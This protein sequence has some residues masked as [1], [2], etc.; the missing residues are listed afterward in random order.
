M[1]NKITK[2]PSIS[3]V[4]PG[5]KAV[6]EVPVKGPTYK[7]ILFVLTGTDLDV[8]N[9]GRIDVLFN[10]NV[11]Q[12][13][14]NLQRL[15]DLNGYYNRSVDSVGATRI[16][17]MLSFFS[18]Q[19]DNLA[20]KLAT[21]IGTAD[22][23][24]FNIEMEIASGAPA[25]IKMEATAYI[26]TMPQPIG[27]FVGFREYGISS[28][29]T[30]EIETD[31]LGKQGEVYHALHLAKSDISKVTIE[32]DGIKVIEATKKD[33]ERYQK[34]ASPKARAPVSAGYTHVDFLL[35]GNAGDVLNTRNVND[36]RLKM[37]FDT[38][39]AAEIIA[40]TLETL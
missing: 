30:G 21:G 3:R 5:S 33:L 15:I 7:K 35:D 39:G 27:A 25:D 31:K 1:A 10:G 19:Y 2:L 8:S 26:D 40:E 38:V 17:F 4:V 14:K 29:V 36:L 34:D 23:A 16:E 24:S 13:F 37:V 22:L 20:Y 18:A 9:I 6:L 11:R 32:A 12:T 28:S